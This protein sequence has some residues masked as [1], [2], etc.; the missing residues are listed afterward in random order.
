MKE[1]IKYIVEFI[2]FTA[3][4]SCVV[5]II[6]S[7]WHFDLLWIFHT[8]NDGIRVF[9]IAVSFVILFRFFCLL[10]RIHFVRRKEEEEMKRIKMKARILCIKHCIVLLGDEIFSWYRSDLEGC[11]R[12]TFLRMLS[13]IERKLRH[14]R[15]LC[16]KEIK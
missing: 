6:F 7:L 15:S 10:E 13:V 14:I 9:V 12:E 1:K 8:T 4:Y 5:Y 11:D 2:T 3:L 16:E